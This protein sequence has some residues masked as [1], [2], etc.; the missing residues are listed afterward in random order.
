LA[1]AGGNVRFANPPYLAGPELEA[2]GLVYIS[3]GDGG[4]L[5]RRWRSNN[6]VAVIPSLALHLDKEVNK[7]VEINVQ[8]HLAALAPFHE[9]DTL[10]PL[11]RGICESLNCGTEEILSA[12]IYLVPAAKSEIIGGNDDNGFV[13][14]SRLDNLA[15][16]HAILSGLPIPEVDTQDGRPGILAAWFDAEEVGSRTSSGA[17]S[18]FLDEIIER[19]VLASGGGRED[20]MRTRRRS[21]MIS[22]DM[23]HAVHPNYADKHDSGYSPRMGGGPVLKSH[24]QKH[25]ATDAQSEAGMSVI[26]ARSGITMQKL[27]FRSDLA[28]GFSL[29]PLASAGSSIPAVDIGS[30]LWGMHSSRETASLSDHRDMIRLLQELWA[31]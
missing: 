31:A 18:L 6:A 28:C 19:L 14:S 1:N 15:M 12:E 26:A 16:A 17:L 20:L 3:D 4:V 25:Y 11:L 23:A 13:V 30:P 8:Q 22:A 10:N 9:S 27:I 29:G 7:G 21:F 2:A 5:T 24:G